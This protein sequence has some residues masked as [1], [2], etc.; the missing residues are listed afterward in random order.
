MGT[1]GNAGVHQAPSPPPDEVA[2][3]VYRSVTES[4]FRGH[5][6]RLETT[7]IM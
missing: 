5:M 3:S 6:S 4:R 1:L 7:I 2:D